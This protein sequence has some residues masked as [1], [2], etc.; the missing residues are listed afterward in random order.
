MKW[1]HLTF[2]LLICY[3]SFYNA[4]SALEPNPQPFLDTIKEC[5]NSKNCLIND[6]GNVS[7]S[8]N[9]IR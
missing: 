2:I 4:V 6:S 1:L 9:E 3:F 7:S 5:K 8:G